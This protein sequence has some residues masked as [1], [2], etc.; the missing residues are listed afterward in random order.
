MKIEISLKSCLRPRE[1][2]EI[3]PLNGQAIALNMNNENYYSFD[4]VS[5]QIYQQL[6][7]SK[8]IEEA[9]SNL[10]L[11]FEASKET[12]TQDTLELATQLVQEDF[13]QTEIV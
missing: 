6:I 10:E 3:R 4:D 7:T 12:L 11:E 8:N 9:V 2:V 5:Y 1:G 13:L